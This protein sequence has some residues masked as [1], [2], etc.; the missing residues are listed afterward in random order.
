MEEKKY[1]KSQLEG[2]VTLAI[3]GGFILGAIFS[4]V[5]ISLV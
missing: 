2:A 4:I 1:T 3:I 5:L